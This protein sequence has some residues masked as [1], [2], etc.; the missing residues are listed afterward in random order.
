[1]TSANREAVH[2]LF[3]SRTFLFK[4]DL[5]WLVGPQELDALLTTD[6]RAVIH[7]GSP[8]GLFELEDSDAA[9]GHYR[10][11]YR[12]DPR[13]QLERAAALLEA[14]VAS[15]RDARNILRLTMLV[16]ESDADGRRLADRCTLACDGALPSMLERGGAREATI[17]YSRVYPTDGE[18]AAAAPVPT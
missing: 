16:A 4:T 14:I 9:A 5:P 2:E 8:V 1:V 7:A 3:A 17:F 10:L 15:E 12:C 18:A 6:T 11:H 13:V